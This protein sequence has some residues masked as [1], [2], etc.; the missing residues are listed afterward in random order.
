[1]T[2]GHGR[3]LKI[4]VFLPHFD[5]MMAGATPRWRDIVETAQR[6]EDLGFD[7][8]WVADHLL[9]DLAR[10]EDGLVGA[11]ECWSLLAALAAATTRVSLGSL[12][13]CTSFRQPPLLAKMA[14]TIDEIS[15]GRLILGLGA[16]WND[17]EYRAF[18][19]PTDRRVSR[20]AEALTIIHTLLHDGQVDVTGQ[21]YQVRDC[22]LRPRGPRPHG[23]PLMVGSVGPRMMR[24]AAQY[25]DS[26]NAWAD[27]FNNRP[28]GLSELHAAVDAA[29]A[30]VGRDP[31][32]LERTAT[33]LV[34]L[35]GAVAYPAG[36]PGWDPGEGGATLAADP[37]ALAASLR[38]FA[39]AGVTHLQVWVN[40]CT[41]AGI[42]A[43]APVLDILDHA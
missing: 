26:W 6:A 24:L 19:Y 12:V 17:R 36:Y 38:A 23:P 43:L 31:Q 40:P 27:T 20:F 33:V 10:P 16:G 8:V 14:E 39:R 1:M 15:G 7:S 32:T 2:T 35:P 5:D 3:P 25:A 9:F 28:D 22:V 29:C 34:E 42:D 30:E 4:G 21:Y 13:T 11:W 37:D 18:G 41:R